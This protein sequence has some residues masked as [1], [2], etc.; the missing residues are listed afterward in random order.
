MRR[1][2]YSGNDRQASWQE[3]E[4]FGELS[5]AFGHGPHHVPGEPTTERES[6][7]EVMLVACWRDAIWQLNP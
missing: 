6:F 7:S 3:I 1:I 5:H 4:W 2:G